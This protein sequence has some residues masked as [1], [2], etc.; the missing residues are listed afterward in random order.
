MKSN[1]NTPQAQRW[2]NEMGW[3]CSTYVSI[4]KRIRNLMGRPLGS[5]RRS[6]EDIKM[7]LREVGCDAGEW[8]DLAEDWDQWGLI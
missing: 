5:P 4:Y 1:D 7:D 2:S 6:S 8:I 3:T